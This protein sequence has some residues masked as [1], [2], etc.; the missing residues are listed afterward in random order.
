MATTD[1]LFFI[2]NDDIVPFLIST[3]FDLIS[4]F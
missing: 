1:T 2:N 4:I 3:C